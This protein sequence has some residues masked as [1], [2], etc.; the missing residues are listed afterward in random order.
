LTFLQD[1]K[2]RPCHALIDESLY[3]EFD[4]ADVIRFPRSNPREPDQ[5]GWL[6]VSAPFDVVRAVLPLERLSI[7]VGYISQPV[8][9][10]SQVYFV[11]AIG[12]QKWLRIPY[13][14]A[15][16]YFEHGQV[17]GKGSDFYQVL[18]VDRKA[19]PKQI[20]K[21]YY[22]LVKRYHHDGG[23]RPDEQ[24][25]QRINDAYDVLSDTEEREKYDRMVYGKG[26]SLVGWPGS[27]AG[28]LD[29]M[30]EDRGSLVCAVEILSFKRDQAVQRHVFTQRDY[31]SDRFYVHSGGRFIQLTWLYE[32]ESHSFDV[33][34]TAHPE[35][36][37]AIEVDVEY[38]KRA[39]W[40]SSRGEIRYTWDVRN[41]NVVS[42][43]TSR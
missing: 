16:T 40:N 29:I 20:K 6:T 10:S 31:G 14:I 42:L 41:V 30:S 39:H 22:E 5:E 28:V 2:G 19:S 1:Y 8:R 3:N 23:M 27:G 12:S 36:P 7:K 21:S 43:V 17:S 13:D 26:A 18:G 15:K 34:N 11:T 33:P 25:M 32:S 24:I 9:I 35:L 4:V 37:R 38:R